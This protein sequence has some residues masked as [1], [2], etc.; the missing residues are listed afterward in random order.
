M[1]K[2]CR[3]IHEVETVTEKTRWSIF[4]I[5]VAGTTS[6]TSRETLELAVDSGTEVHIINSFEAC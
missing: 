1:K 5:E 4:M 3:E 2:D 6:G